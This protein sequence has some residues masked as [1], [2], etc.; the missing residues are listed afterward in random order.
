MLTN[1]CLIE[2]KGISSYS[3]WTKQHKHVF[4]AFPLWNNINLNQG[5]KTKLSPCT[6]N[7][8]RHCCIRFYAYVEQP[9]SKELYVKQTLIQKQRTMTKLFLLGKWLS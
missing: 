4:Y 7:T 9:V 1:G 5:L 8:N 2:G 3:N 6:P